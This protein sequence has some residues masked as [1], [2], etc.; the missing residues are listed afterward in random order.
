MWGT[1][2]VFDPDSGEWVAVRP[3]TLVYFTFCGLPLGWIW[4]LM[5]CQS[6]MTRAVSTAL[7]SI[8]RFGGFL[9][10]DRCPGPLLDRGRFLGAV[11][12]DNA[13]IIGVDKRSTDAGISAVRAY[14]DK[15]GFQYHEFVPPSHVVETV[16]LEL[17]LGRDLEVRQ[18]SK[19]A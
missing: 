15:A 2:Q 7:S 12:V 16:G 10:A 11:Y 6:V 3:D 18:T 13:T 4:A 5:F 14:M 17:R 1:E 19:R 9:I 8:N